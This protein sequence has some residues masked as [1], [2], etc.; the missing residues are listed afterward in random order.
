MQQSFAILGKKNVFFI[1]ITRGNIIVQDE[2]AKAQEKDLKDGGLR[3]AALDTTDPEPLGQ[4][5]ELWD[6]DNFSVTPHISGV[7]R[8]IVHRSLQ[9]LEANLQNFLGGKDLSIL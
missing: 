2:L 8:A 9:V 5:S 4:Y 1:N 7:S 3:G 6:L